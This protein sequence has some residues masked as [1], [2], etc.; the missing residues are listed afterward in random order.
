L[1]EHR[2]DFTFVNHRRLSREHILDGLSGH[3]DVHVQLGLLELQAN[4][5]AHGITEFLLVRCASGWIDES[6]LG[7]A[8]QGH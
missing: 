4:A 7:H 5:H 1:V 8:G 6:F 2:S 3:F